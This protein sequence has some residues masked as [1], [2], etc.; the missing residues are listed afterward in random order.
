MVAQDTRQGLLALVWKFGAG[1]E[2]V[3]AVNGEEAGTVTVAGVDCTTTTAK[4]PTTTTSATTD[5]TSTTADSPGFGLL[6]G[7][8]ALLG[9]ALLARDR[10]P[11]L[12]NF[13]RKY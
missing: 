9:A 13:L 1:G 7:F 8:L 5:S 4:E 2:Y 6:V 10:S 11:L 3:L 12:L